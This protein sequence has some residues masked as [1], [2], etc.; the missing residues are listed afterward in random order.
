MVRVFSPREAIKAA[1]KLGWEEWAAKGGHEFRDPD[2]QRYSCRAPGRA[3]RVPIDLARALES[4]LKQED[5]GRDD[6][7]QGD[8]GNA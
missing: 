5:E 7:R 3:D 1:R 4:A 6:R 8:G 2:G